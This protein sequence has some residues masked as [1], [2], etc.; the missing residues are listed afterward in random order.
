MALGGVSRAT[1]KSA[2]RKNEKITAPTIRSFID[3]LAEAAR[4]ERR[5]IPLVGLHGGICR[6][7]GLFGEKQ[8][9]SYA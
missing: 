5:Q 4:E 1:G 9:I 6:S 2:T 8:H 3:G 7:N